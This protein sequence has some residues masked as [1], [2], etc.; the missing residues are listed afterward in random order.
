MKLPLQMISDGVWI[1]TFVFPAGQQFV[2]FQDIVVTAEP[3][4]GVQEPNLS[5]IALIGQFSDCRPQ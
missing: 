1:G 5:R 4:T 3:N 2:P